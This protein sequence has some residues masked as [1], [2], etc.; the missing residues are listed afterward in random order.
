MKYVKTKH[1]VAYLF[2]GNGNKKENWEKELIYTIVNVPLKQVIMMHTATLSPISVY[3]SH[4][5]KI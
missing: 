3:A 2:L 5:V 1:F 4:L